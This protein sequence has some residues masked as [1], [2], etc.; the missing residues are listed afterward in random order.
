MVSDTSDL[1]VTEHEE[2]RVEK[3][4]SQIDNL[5][6]VDMESPSVHKKKSFVNSD[7]KV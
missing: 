6:S 5:K 4:D 1:K 2:L 7:G 3:K